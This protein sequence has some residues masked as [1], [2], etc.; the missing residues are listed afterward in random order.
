MNVI[1]G[2][3]S[4]ERLASDPEYTAGKSP[5]IVRAYRKLMTL[6]RNADDE[7]D[8]YNL[9]SLHFEKLHGKRKHQHSMRINDQYRLII[10]LN[11]E[12]LKRTVVTIIG[13]ED[14]H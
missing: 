13:I 10:E 14:Y 12:T 3:D 6:I 9:K 8:F 5:A 7:R 4:L 11:K 2:D 1:F